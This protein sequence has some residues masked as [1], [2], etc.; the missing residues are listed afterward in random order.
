MRLARCGPRSAMFV[1]VVLSLVAGPFG[2]RVEGAA[3]EHSDTGA[4]VRLSSNGALGAEPAVA[5]G[6]NGLAY[7]VWVEHRGSDADAFAVRL[8]TDAR[9]A[10]GRDSRRRHPRGLR[11]RLGRYERRTACRRRVEVLREQGVYAI[12]AVDRHAV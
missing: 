11:R 1:A 5:V 12:G 7:A 8:G 4:P 3:L 2:L 9:P 6:S 10:G